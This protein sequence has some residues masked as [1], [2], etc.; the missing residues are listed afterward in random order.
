MEDL[1]EYHR[2]VEEYKAQKEQRAMLNSRIAEFMGE[3][4]WTKVTFCLSMQSFRLGSPVKDAAMLD[5]IESCRECR[6]RS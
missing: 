3:D 1:S 5:S 6:L 4:D 2:H